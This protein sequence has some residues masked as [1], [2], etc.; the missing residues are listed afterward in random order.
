LFSYAREWVADDALATTPATTNADAKTNAA[1]ESQVITLYMLSGFLRNPVQ[2]FF[3]QRLKVYLDEATSA[4]ADT[5][6]FALD[7]LQRYQM[8]NELLQ[9]ARALADDETQAALQAAAGKLQR[10]GS[11]PLSGFGEQYQKDLLEPLPAQLQEYA[12]L[13]RNWSQPLESP[14]PLHFEQADI[15]LEDG[16]GNLR[17]NDDGHLAFIELS[18]GTLKNRQ[19]K[20][21]RLLPTYVRHVVVAACDVELTSLLVGEDEIARFD[22]L[23]VDDARHILNDWL[24]GWQEGMRRPLPVAYKT[25]FAQLAGKDATQTYDGG[26]NFDGEASESPTLARVYPDFAALTQDGEFFDWVERL[27]APLYAQMQ[28]AQA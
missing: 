15:R 1:Q 2:Y 21:H 17:Q 7:G 8:Q 25:A 28:D 11:L 18:P 12:T 13:C 9:A 19:W 24:N 27:Y 6:P 10:S 4:V 16:I 5:E 22:P 20:W 14:K 26:F 3:N 23:P